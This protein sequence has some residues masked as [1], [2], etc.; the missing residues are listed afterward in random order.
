MSSYILFSFTRHLVDYHLRKLRAGTSSS[1]P[2]PFDNVSFHLCFTFL[3]VLFTYIVFLLFLSFKTQKERGKKRR[4][5]S[6]CRRLADWETIIEHR[7]FFSL[8]LIVDWRKINDEREKKRE[9]RETHIHS[10]K[11]IVWEE[12]K[13]RVYVCSLCVISVRKKIHSYNNLLFDWL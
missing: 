10:R 11:I 2:A 8:V 7:R 1:F 3:F 9:K 5:A 12:S 13:K 4:R 6:N